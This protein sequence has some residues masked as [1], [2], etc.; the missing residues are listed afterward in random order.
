MLYSPDSLRASERYRELLIGIEAFPSLSG[1]VILA[2][3]GSGKTTFLQQVAESIGEGA[4][5]LRLGNYVNDPLGLRGEVDA[6]LELRS[7]NGDSYLL[8]DALDENSEIGGPLVRLV[9]A[10]TSRVNIHIWVASRL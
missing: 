4:K 3:G 6:F 1:G 10:N 5:I 9:N 8:F 2:E 7:G